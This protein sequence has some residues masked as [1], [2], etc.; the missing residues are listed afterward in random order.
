MPNFSSI[1]SDNFQITIQKENKKE[2]KLAGKPNVEG[3][4]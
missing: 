1:L 3:H 2:K 4:S